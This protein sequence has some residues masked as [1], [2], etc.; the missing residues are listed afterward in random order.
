VARDEENAGDVVI[1]LA[2]NDVMFVDVLT[3]KGA[4]ALGSEKWCT[5]TSGLSN[6]QK[7]SGVI[8]LYVVSNGRRMQFDLEGQENKNESNVEYTSVPKDK[9]LFGPIMKQYGKDVKAIVKARLTATDRLTPIS[10]FLNEDPSM[11][12]VFRKYLKAL[13]D[14]QANS[15]KDTYI[16]SGQSSLLMPFAWLSIPKNRELVERIF[17]DQSL[18]TYP[19]FQLLSKNIDRRLL[20]VEFA[21][22]RSPYICK[23]LQKV[24]NINWFKDSRYYPEFRY[25]EDGRKFNYVIDRRAAVNY[26]MNLFSFVGIPGGRY[27]YQDDYVWIDPIQMMKYEMTRGFFLVVMG[28]NAGGSWHD[29]DDFA[30]P[31]VDVNWFEAC[32]CANQCSLMYGY[33]GVYTNQRGTLYTPSDAESQEKCEWDHNREGF[34]LPTEAEWEIAARGGDETFAGTTT[35]YAGSSEPLEVAWFDDNSNS[36]VHVVGQLKPN[37][38]GLY[39]MT[40]NVNEWVWD[41]YSGDEVSFPLRDPQI[42]AKYKKK[43]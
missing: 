39:D 34:R 27:R 8:L 1:L 23:G 10:D 4:C 5:V 31:K 43:K 41:T 32:A 16:G 22:R 28:W 29:Y 24:P 37:G 13:H 20:K 30:K 36:R 25:D 35:D 17:N 2:N 38:F 26:N 7:K 11:M 21:I 19:N 6:Q 14:L 9:A 42:R 33:E 15:P 40:G 12:V 18:L 3:T